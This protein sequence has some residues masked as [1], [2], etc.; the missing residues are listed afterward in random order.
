[1][2]RYAPDL[3]AQPNAS[4]RRSS[5][6]VHD[7]SAA[8]VRM[9]P[10]SG[11]A[12]YRCSARIRSTGLP[13]AAGQTRLL[14]ASGLIGA[15][16]QNVEVHYVLARSQFLVKSDRRIVAVVGLNIDHPRSPPRC[17]LL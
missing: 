11:V 6:Q 9:E 13:G 1:M 2:L 14:R 5:L 4:L 17:N 10:R 3:H 12:H 8:I 16:H 15:R 7:E